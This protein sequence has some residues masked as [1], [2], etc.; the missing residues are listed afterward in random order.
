LN[1]VV[2]SDKPA[3]VN[4]VESTEKEQEISNST[5]ENYK[6]FQE[7]EFKDLNEG[8]GLGNEGNLAQ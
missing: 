1:K 6:K 3:K 7:A 8:E 2:F 5:L 4:P